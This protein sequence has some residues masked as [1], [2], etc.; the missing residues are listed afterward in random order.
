MTDE[1]KLAPNQRLCIMKYALLVS[2]IQHIVPQKLAP[3]YFIAEVLEVGVMELDPL[4]ILNPL[5]TIVPP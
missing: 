5:W 3:I 4:K 1:N 2:L